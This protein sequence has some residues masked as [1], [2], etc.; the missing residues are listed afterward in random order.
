MLSVLFG[1]SCALAFAERCF[2]AGAL[3]LV[4]SAI[5]D[6]VDGN[7][8]RKN[9]TESK[10]GA[11]FDWVADKYVDAAVILGVGFSGIPI[12]SHLVD[13]PPIA[14]FGVVGLALTGSLINTFIK[15]VTYA[16]IGYTERIAGKIEDP[17]EGVGFFG[18]PETILVLVLGGVTG[19]IWVAVLLIAVCTNLSAIQRM[20][21]LYR[22]YS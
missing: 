13:V 20:V 16:E 11:V 19:Y 10:F 7:V 14:D 21:Y 4:V 3:L 18:R 15:P 8:A 17:L 5:L 1:F 2:L 9:H 22:R 12:I 6:L